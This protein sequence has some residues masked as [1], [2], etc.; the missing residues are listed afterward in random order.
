MTERWVDRVKRDVEA[1]LTVDG[2]N[3]DSALRWS[4]RNAYLKITEERLQQGKGDLAAIADAKADAI[5]PDPK[6]IELI[7]TGER[8][9]G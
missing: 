7:A 4:L 2:I 6:I 9:T 3:R 8:K 5:E 1:L